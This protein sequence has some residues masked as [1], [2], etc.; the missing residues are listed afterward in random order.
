VESICNDEDVIQENIKLTKL[1]NPDY[2][3]ITP[4]E[5]FISNLTIG[6]Q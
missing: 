5:V 2:A 4:E 6:N 3:N 1:S